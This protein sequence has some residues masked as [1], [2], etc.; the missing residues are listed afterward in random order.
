MPSSVIEQ[1]KEIKNEMDRGKYLENFD[2]LE[3]M[4]D[5]KELTQEEVIRGLIILCRGYFHMIN[6]RYH[7]TFPDKY[8]GDKM[9]IRIDQLS[10]EISKSKNLGFVFD[11]EVLDFMFVVFSADYPKLDHSYKNLTEIFEEIKEKDPDLRKR[12]EGMFHVISGYYPTWSSYGGKKIADNYIEE[13]RKHL[14]EA[15][16]STTESDDPFFVEIATYNY[17]INFYWREGKIEKTLP[18]ID[19]VIEVTE[20]YGNDYAKAFYISYYIQIYKALGDQT[21]RLEYLLKRKEL[22]DKVEMEGR[23][24]NHKGYMATYYKDQ[25]DLDKALKNYREIIDYFKE[26]GDEKS[27]SNLNEMIGEILL[28][29]GE[30]IEAEEH[31]KQ[32]YSFNLEN[33]FEGWWSVFPLMAKTYLLKGDL[34]NARKIYEEYLAI[35]ENLQV[36]GVILHTLKDLSLVLWQMGKKEEALEYAW[37]SYEVVSETD[38][39]LWKGFILVNL[40]FLL[41]EYDELDSAESKL[42]EFNEII[43]ET[44]ER[45]LER[46]FRFSEAKLLLQKEDEKNQLRAE[47]LLEGLLKEKLDYQDYVNVVTSLTELLFLRLYETNDKNIL[48]KIQSYVLDLFS[49]ASSNQSFLLITESLLLQSKLALLELNIEKSKELLDKAMKLAEEKGLKRIAEIVKKERTK[50]KEDIDQLKSLDK[51]TDFNKKMDIL[52]IKTRVNGFKKSGITAEKVQETE[53]SKKLLSI[54]I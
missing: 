30:L 54:K 24:E 8:Y 42:V 17:L 21:K 16:E 51:E 39:L 43:S 3:K 33:R 5:E 35:G 13:G 53:F 23:E 27:L 32:S 19:N 15:L 41:V 47:I 11:K 38:S 48:N 36:K 4:L 9:K 50:F 7:I 28:K 46:S 45:D 12:K 1:L 6:W 34:D 29:K 2:I 31:I 52:H 25:G 18:M 49:L 26:I 37:R 44:N 14:K 10:K 20:R 40:I 22:W